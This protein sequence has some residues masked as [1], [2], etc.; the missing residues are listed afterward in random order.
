L[1]ERFT[2]IL[3]RDRYQREAKQLANWTV[4]AHAP[5]R[6]I[7]LQPQ[8]ALPG[9]C[10]IDVDIA[11]FFFHRSRVVVSHDDDPHTIT[12]SEHLVLGQRGAIQL[13]C[14]HQHSSEAWPRRS[15]RESPRPKDRVREKSD[16]A[17]G[18]NADSTVQ[19]LPEKCFSSVF[20]ENVVCCRRPAS[21]QRAF[22]PIVTEREAGMRWTCRC[23][24]TSGIGADGEVV[25]SWHPDAD[26][27]RARDNL[28][29][30]GAKKPGPR[31]EYEGHR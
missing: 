12:N 23:R 8:P 27:K 17:R 9:V 21:M 20:R 16:F 18:F 31:G 7:L 11:P 3:L 24:Q 6:L 14:A 5:L 30:T 15:A 28:L 13:L 29:V 26:A 25:W 10:G 22:W 19:P 2:G 4:S 1:P